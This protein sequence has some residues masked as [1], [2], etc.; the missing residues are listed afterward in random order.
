VVRRVLTGILTL[1]GLVVLAA[2]I[3]IWWGA[4]GTTDARLVSPSVVT[5]QAQAPGAAD[6]GETPSRL[7]A[8]AW[9]IA[10]GRGPGDDTDGPWPE[11]T[12][13]RNLDAIAA[14][15]LASGADLAALQEV[16]LGAARSY[17]VHQGRY[18]LDRLGW[19]AM[20]CVV[21]WENNYVPFPYWP[22]D[23]HFG[24]MRSGQCLLSRW[25]IEGATRYRLPQPAANPFWYNWFY[26][27]RAID[28]AV[29]RAG[30]VTL[31]VLNLHLEAFDIPNREDHIRQLIEL[32]GDVEGEHLLALGDYNALPP[33]ASTHT[34]FEGEPGA[35]YAGDTSM[36]LMAEVPGLSEV[37]DL[38]DAFTF[39]SHAPNR[40]LDYIFHR[41]GLEVVEA[42]VMTEA[43]H[44]SDHLPVI[45]TFTLR[46]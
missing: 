10:Y 39:P 5:L 3:F 25:P 18:L 13:T 27:H 23:R 16:D 26:L 28:H 21:T 4:G 22:P 24:R 40:R 14:L 15:I 38:A 17:D 31:E 20:S 30:G 35:D 41:E 37:L 6:P 2:L 42:R 36:T 7:T 32:L 8:I 11:E 9:N 43:A 46:R 33:T 44:L 29:V 19:P 34:G 45:A 1:V 12:F